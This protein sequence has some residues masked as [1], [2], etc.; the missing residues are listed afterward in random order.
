MKQGDIW[1]HPKHKDVECLAHHVPRERI[2][3]DAPCICGL[4]YMEECRID[5]EYECLLKERELLEDRKE[6]KV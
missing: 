5:M 4:R 6:R 1:F 2:R 3:E